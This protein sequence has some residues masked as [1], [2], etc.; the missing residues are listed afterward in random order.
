MRPSSERSDDASRLARLRGLLDRAEGEGAARLSGQDLLEL[1]RLYRFAASHLA[2]METAAGESAGSAKEPVRMLVARAHALLHRGLERPR[3]G[4]IERSVAFILR[5]VPRAIRGEWRVIAAS[6]GLTYGLAVLSFV[7]VRSDLDLAWSLMSPEMVS[8]EVGQLEATANGEPFR[9]NF[10]FGLGKS[11][12]T[13]GWIM[14]HN[15]SV[16]ILFFGSG[17]VPP[18]FLILLGV[19]GLMLGTYTAVAWHWGQALS[20][21]S[22]LWCHGVLEIQAIVLAGAAGLVLVRA[23]IAP[24]PWSRGHAM[25]LESRRAWKLLAPVFPML[26]VAGLIEGFVSPHAPLWVR[27]GTAA[28][29][30]IAIVAWVRLGGRSDDSLGRRSRDGAE[31]MRS[32]L[33]CERSTSET[34][35]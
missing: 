5:E 27:V 13:A 2:R 6:F 9:G 4:W 31:K 3:Q 29:S 33:Y 15:M 22:I 24:G 8:Q 7:A 30:A 17:L 26:F 32:E 21:S 11:P 25:K 1:P 16:G 18:I 28:L 35:E 34:S 10:T 14:T 19:N 23:W 12:L 20:I